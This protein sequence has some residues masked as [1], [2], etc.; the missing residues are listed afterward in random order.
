VKNGKSS[1]AF[2]YDAA[3]FTVTYTRRD[4]TSEES[5]E[6]ILRLIRKNQEITIQEL[7]VALNRST[8]SIEMQLQSLKDRN[9]IVRIGPDK[10]KISK[11]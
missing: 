8:R 10:G 4:E 2:S 1:V 3:F 11:K 5:S 6:K 7:A 9:Q